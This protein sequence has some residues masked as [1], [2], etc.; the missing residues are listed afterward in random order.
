LP[1]LRTFLRYDQSCGDAEGA[2]WGTKIKI[3]NHG[4]THAQLQERAAGWWEE[5]IPPLL[6]ESRANDKS[7]TVLIVGHGAFLR[8]LIELIT[9]D[10]RFRIEPLP[11]QRAR[12]ILPNTGISTVEIFDEGNEVYG[13]LVSYGDDKHIHDGHAGETPTKENVDDLAA[14]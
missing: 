10:A 6:H 7:L 8:T 1:Q 11:N 4:E 2:V 12:W 13:K 5:N 14:E 9:S 3:K